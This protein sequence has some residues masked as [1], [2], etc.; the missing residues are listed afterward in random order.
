MSKIHFMCIGV[1]GEFSISACKKG[2][3][4]KST[5]DTSRVTCLS[6]RS[7]KKWRLAVLEHLARQLLSHAN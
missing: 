1:S 6:C 7:T 4:S 3:L 2:L 5:R